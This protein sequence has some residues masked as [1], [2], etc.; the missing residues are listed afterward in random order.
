MYRPTGHLQSERRNIVSR[1]AIELN[2]DAGDSVFV[3]SNGTVSAGTIYAHSTGYYLSHNTGITLAGGTLSC[4]NFT[5]DDGG[6]RL[7]QSGGALVVSNLLDFGG[8]RERGWEPSA[9]L[10]PLH[11][12]RRDADCE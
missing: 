11:I 10:R 8:S 4:S 7:N 3:Q 6:G 1:R 9:H 2:A 12:H 5:T